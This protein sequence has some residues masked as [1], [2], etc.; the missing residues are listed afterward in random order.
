L[1]ALKRAPKQVRRSNMP[2]NCQNSSPLGDLPSHLQ[3]CGT[4]T[5]RASRQPPALNSKASCTGNMPADMDGCWVD[6]DIASNP[7]QDR[8]RRVVWP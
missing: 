6:R 7:L 4:V 1:G 8:T 2:S 5:A 3:R